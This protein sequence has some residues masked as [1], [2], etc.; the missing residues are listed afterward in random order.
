MNDARLTAR[1]IISR[2]NMSPRPE[3]YSGRGARL[4]DLNGDQLEAIYDLV[5][6]EYGDEAARNF[7]YLVAE[8]DVLSATVFLN[9]FYRLGWNDWKRLD[10][11]PTTDLDQLDP[12]PDREDGSQAAVGQM[13][14]ANFLSGSMDRD[15]TPAIRGQFLC[16]HAE[17]L[18]EET[19]QR[20]CESQMRVTNDGGI[21]IS[22]PNEIK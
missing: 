10:L 1:Q 18:D 19:R 6:R 9:N 4:G 2:C 17:E 13:M 8:T 14:M 5:K 15:E 20:V 11:Q 21:M 3:C 7:V 16:D 22:Y 12:G